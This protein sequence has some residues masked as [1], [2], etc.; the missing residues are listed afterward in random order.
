MARNKV[1]N[2]LNELIAEEGHNLRE[3]RTD[4][5]IALDLPV[6]FESP[7]KAWVDLNPLVMFDGI[8][9]LVQR[10]LELIRE[11]CF[12]G[13]SDVSVSLSV[14]RSV[15]PQLYDFGI[16]QVQFYSPVENLERL[17]VLYEIMSHQLHYIFNALQSPSIGRDL[18]INGS[19]GHTQ[20][21]A[22]LFP[23]NRASEGDTSGLHYLIERKKGTHFLRITAEE[24][25]NNRINLRRIPH[26]VVSGIELIYDYFNIRRE[27]QTIFHSIVARSNDNKIA[28]HDSGLQLAT[29]IHFLL[30]S[31]YRQLSGIT[32]NW[33]REIVSELLVKNNQNWYGAICRMLLILSDSSVV[34]L[35]SSGAE[36]ETTYCNTRIFLSLSQK[37]RNLQIDLQERVSIVPLNQYLEKMGQLYRVAVGFE[38]SLENVHVILIHHFTAETLAVLGAFDQMDVGAVDTL[39]VKYGGG[40]PSEF[41]ETTLSLPGSLYR[42]YGLQPIHKNN[43]EQ[44]FCLS[45]QVSST[46]YFLDLQKHFLERKPEFFEAMQCLAM[47]LF[48]DVF[49]RDHSGRTVIIAEDGGYLAPLVNRL[50]L[51]NRTVGEVFDAYNYKADNISQGQKEQRFFNWISPRY[52]GSVEHTR[53]GYDALKEVESRFSTLAFPAATLAVSHFKVFE[54][55]IEVAYSCINAIENILNSHGFVFNKRTCLVLGSLG[56]IGWQTM[57]IIRNRVGK[58]QLSGI[59]RKTIENSHCEWPQFASPDELPDDIRYT[60][61]LIFGVIGQSIL[62]HTFFDDLTRNTRCSR[63]FLASGSTKRVE[64]RDFLDWAASLSAASNPSVSGIPVRISTAE[65]EDPQTS[66][67]QGTIFRIEFEGEKRG[68]TIEYYL[69]GNL[70]PVNFQYYG[71][72]RET[73]DSVM[74]HFVMLVNRIAK[75]RG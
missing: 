16:Y 49:T 35:L 72:P 29:L 31:G 32:L 58:K 75:A 36:I 62:D 44:G 9:T 46:D 70:M 23:F 11:S 22:I 65:L 67:L 30:S 33:T 27:A 1:T 38:K 59:D 54:E 42:F 60:S 37:N 39:W 15:C 3:K 25:E 71:V 55:S 20:D 45:K 18:L 41:L 61:D 52:A 2:V 43:L 47:H 10:L 48:L 57:N 12:W 40:I 28:F 66:V 64:F 34:E 19:D 69:L 53:N 7:Y 50:S 6:D 14:E 5:I 17:P 63:L 8:E 4:R 13:Q 24:Q 73:M 26:R 51:E 21:S 74:V 56:A 68:R